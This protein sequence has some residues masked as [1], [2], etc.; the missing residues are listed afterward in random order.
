MNQLGGPEARTRFPTAQFLNALVEDE[1][2]PPQG[3]VALFGFGSDA[4]PNKA[5][6]GSDAAPKAQK[7]SDVD[8]QAGTVPAPEPAAKPAGSSAGPVTGEAEA[9]PGIPEAVLKK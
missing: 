4:A 6:T 1:D 5:H 7:G 8:P 9:N 2:Q 3:T